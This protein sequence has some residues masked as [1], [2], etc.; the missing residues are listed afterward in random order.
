MML[1][2]LLVPAYLLAWVVVY[3][4][5]CGAIHAGSQDDYLEAALT[6]TFVAVFVPIVLPL[7]AV[8][9]TVARLYRPKVNTKQGG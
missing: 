6:A 4:Y 1:L 3:R 9:A 7:V 2:W 8:L 5:L